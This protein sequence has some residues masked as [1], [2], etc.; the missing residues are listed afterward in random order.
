MQARDGCIDKLLGAHEAA[1]HINQ[2]SGDQAARGGVEVAARNEWGGRNAD[3]SDGFQEHRPGWGEPVHALL[4]RN[5][6]AAV[7]KAHDNFYARQ[8]LDGIVYLMVPQ[9]SFAGTD[10]IRD[11]KSYGYTQGVFRGNSGHVR[12]S[13]SPEQATI[14]YVRACLPAGGDGATRNGAVADSHV[15][16]PYGARP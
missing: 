10:L 7:F 4:V 9:P 13:V 16:L 8:A 1:R 2:L 3:G 11:L 6:V 14:E 15:I 12:V 5:H